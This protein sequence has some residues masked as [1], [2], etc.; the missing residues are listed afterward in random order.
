MPGTLSLAGQKHR[1]VTNSS[2]QSI[3]CN[4]E[5]QVTELHTTCLEILH[6]SFWTHLKIKYSEVRIWEDE[7]CLVRTTTW[8]GKVADVCVGLEINVLGHDLFIYLWMKK[9]RLQQSRLE[10]SASLYCET[11]ILHTY[12]C[13]LSIWDVKYISSYQWIKKNLRAFYYP[14]S[15]MPQL[16]GEKEAHG[17]ISTC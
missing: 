5:R 1:A 9:D 12:L 16:W 15:T 6:S 14:K 17:E 8:K 13:I 10:N 3:S 11:F 2:A 7:A 4:W